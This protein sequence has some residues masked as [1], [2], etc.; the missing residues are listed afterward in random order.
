MIKGGAMSIVQILFSANGRIRRRD[1][2][3]YSIGIG[4]VGAL[5]EFAGHQVLTGHP[6]S[7]YV[8]D[9]SGWMS[10]KP[11]PFNLFILA[12]MVV[13][14]WPAICIVSKRWHDRGKSGWLSV[15]SPGSTIL[16]LCAQGF[17]GPLSPHS[18][19]GLYFAG[20]LINLAISIWVFV[21]CG[22]LDGTKGSNR[23]GPSPKGIQDSAAVF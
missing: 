13:F 11:E 9:L 8:K 23:Y 12:M 18:N 10:F 2:W 4:I 16:M 17:Y 21:E 5:I 1:Y 19:L 7:D 6:A 20:S 3:L 15:I 22:C 14:Q